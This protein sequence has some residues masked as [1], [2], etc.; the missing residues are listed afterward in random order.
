M[1]F[2]CLSGKRPWNGLIDAQIVKKV[3][4]DKI[5]F[6]LNQIRQDTSSIL[7]EIMKQCLNYDKNKR[8]SF[9][10]VELEFEKLMP[11][12]VEKKYVAFISHHKTNT[13]SALATILKSA[14]ENNSSNASA[15]NDDIR[16][17]FVDQE[18]GHLDLSQLF[19]H[20]QE[21]KTLILLLTK[22]VLHRPYCLLELNHAIINKIPII[23][24]RIEG[25]GYEFD[26]V[27]EYLTNLDTKLEKKARNL[28]EENGVNVLDVAY[29]LS[30]VIPNIIAKRYDFKDTERI[31]NAQIAEI[32]NGVQEAKFQN[33]EKSKEE[34]LAIRNKKGK[35]KGR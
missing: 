30:N 5:P 23:T 8:P 35:S 1:I 12:N 21:S 18:E 2:E 11:R 17:V 33:I 6:D 13:A 7:I 22:E 15:S 10:D 19:I 4:V 34:W 20:I 27:E 3:L 29:H 14:L 31:R 16:K 28:I 24:V 26:G 25:E 9:A 32:L